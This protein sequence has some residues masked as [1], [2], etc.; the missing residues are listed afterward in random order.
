MKKKTKTNQIRTHPLSHLHPQSCCH[1]K[2]WP[3]NGS[4]PATAAVSIR[5]LA[6]QQKTKN[7]C[8]SSRKEALQQKTYTCT[9]CLS[10]M[11]KSE[12]PLEFGWVSSGALAALW[13]CTLGCAAHGTAGVVLPWSS[14][15]HCQGHFSASWKMDLF[16]L[17]EVE[18]TCKIEFQ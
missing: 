15:A 1:T 8:A 18:N 3:G 6:L 12:A 2:S 13:H 4:A 16:S 14:R 10:S 7:H 5:H 9:C 17:E 11:E